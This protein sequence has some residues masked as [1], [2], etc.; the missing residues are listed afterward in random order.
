MKVHDAIQSLP[1]SLK[2][3]AGAAF[4]IITDANIGIGLMGLASVY[5]V[6]YA[7]QN[8][9]PKDIPAGVITV[10][11]L[12]FSIRAGYKGMQGWIDSRKPANPEKA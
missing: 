6:V 1:E 10:I 2:P 11:G 5:L 9:P 3:W 12:V 7:V 8:D 4:A